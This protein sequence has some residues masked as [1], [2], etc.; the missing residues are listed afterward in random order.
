MNIFYIWDKILFFIVHFFQLLLFF[1]WQPTVYPGRCSSGE[2]LPATFNFSIYLGSH[3]YS[4]GFSCASPRMLDDQGQ[5]HHVCPTVPELL[6][7]VSYTFC[8]V[9]PISLL[10][11]VCQTWDRSYSFLRCGLLEVKPTFFCSVLFFASF[12]KMGGISFWGSIQQNGMVSDR[13]S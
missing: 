10:N 5:R 13:W 1:E 3:S 12:L 9:C 7:V 4:T 11:S 8:G 2:M 6:W